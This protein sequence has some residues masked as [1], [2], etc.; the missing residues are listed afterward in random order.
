M[1]QIIVKQDLE[2]LSRAVVDEFAQIA[3]RSIFGHGSF[4]V[5]LAGGSTPQHL[6]SMLASESHR[7]K[8]DW[9]RVEFFFGDERHVSPDSEHSNFRMA[10]E[11][12]LEPL[13]ISASRIHRWKSEL[14]DVGKAAD[15]YD[16]ELSKYFER[17]GRPLDLILLGLGEDGHTASLFPNT[18]ALSEI[19]RFAVANRVEKL[20]A[21]RLTMTYSA[22]NDAATVMFIVSGRYKAE[23][24]HAVLDGEFRPD[25]LPAQ[26]V[27]PKSGDLYWMLDE[28]AASLIEKE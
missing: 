24:V 21:D 8:L 3:N 16:A 4:A 12:L 11:T 26:L 10:N 19:E 20:S 6:Y 15:E 25:E 13:E 14:A 5:A 1:R 22:I 9:S 28:D 17:S 23:A 2:E 18:P 27:N 7:V